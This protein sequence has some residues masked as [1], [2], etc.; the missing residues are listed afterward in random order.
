[1]TQVNFSIRDVRRDFG[2]DYRRKTWEKKKKSDVLVRFFILTW[3]PGIGH[4]F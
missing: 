2:A 4:I 1:M 3:K